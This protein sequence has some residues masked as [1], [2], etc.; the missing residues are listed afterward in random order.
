[1]SLL[2]IPITLVAAAAQT[3]RNATQSGLVAA[4]GTVGAT[5]VRF[6]YGLPFAIVFLA[7]VLLVSGES[8]PMPGARS[9]VFALLGASTQIAATALMLSAM[10][11]ESFAVTTALIKTEPVLVAVFGFVVLGDHLGFWK[12]AAILI[13]TLG[14]LL[15][16][17]KPGLA[18]KAVERSRPLM[19]GL[20]A[21]A[22]FGLSAVGF[23]GAILALPHGSFVVRASTILVVGLAMQVVMLVAY[24]AVMNREALTKSL[25][26]WRRSL[27][28]GFF[29]ALASQFWFLG[30]ALTTA[31]NVR[32]LALVEV[33]MALGVSRRLFS[34]TITTREWLGM[35]IVVAGVAL[36]LWA[37]ADP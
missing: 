35:A 5:Q 20:A 9:L 10:K 14:V 33:L 15:L 3:A 17:T 32:T 23:R 22:C 36:L 26:V 13:A 16:S 12:A 25:E 30:F 7:V 29:G 34:Q 6:L 1:M 11:D 37:A 27:V 8:I 2:W 19:L 18:G 4:I 21:G 24:L 28:A 31:A